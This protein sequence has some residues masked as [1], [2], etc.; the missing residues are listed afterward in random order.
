ME[1]TRLTGVPLKR[2]QNTIDIVK[3]EG[4]SHSEIKTYT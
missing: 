3:F 1:R 4:A 2:G